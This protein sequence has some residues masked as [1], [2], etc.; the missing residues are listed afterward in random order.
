MC[1]C[2]E[3][4]RK[5]RCSRAVSFRPG[6]PLAA[7]PTPVRSPP[8][9]L[10]SGDGA[11]CLFRVRLGETSCTDVVSLSVRSCAGEGACASQ[12]RWD[13]NGRHS[14]QPW[15]VPCSPQKR[16]FVDCRRV[17]VH[18]GR[19]GDGASCF[20]SEPRKEFGG[21]DGGDGG[22]GGDI[23]LRGTSRGAARR[24]SLG[25]GGVLPLL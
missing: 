6:P 16:H 3:K 24:R 17:L 4:A 25:G 5:T 21:P 20:H 10:Q 8:R 13:R 14:R 23:I 11:N 12:G 9:C 2:L 1:F 19:G 22:S 7:S 15:G 18:G